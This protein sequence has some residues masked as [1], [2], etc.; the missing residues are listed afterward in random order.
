[1]SLIQALL[2]IIALLGGGFLYQ[3]Q[4]KQSAEA[5]NDNIDTKE[6][7]LDKEKIVK[8]NEA[9]LEVEAERRRVLEEKTKK[10]DDVGIKDL[11]D[12]FNRKPG[13]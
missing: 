7:I 8:E 3:R 11:Q 9:R 10:L 13:E 2:A 6:A 1:M 12:F 5:L 4:K